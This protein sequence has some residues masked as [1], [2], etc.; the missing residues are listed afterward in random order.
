M[1]LTYGSIAKH[2][3]ALVARAVSKPFRMVGGAAAAYG[4][5]VAKLPYKKPWGR[6]VG[7]MMVGGPL[8]GA[9]KAIPAMD[10]PHQARTMNYGDFISQHSI[11]GKIGPEQLNS[12]DMDRALQASQEAGMTKL[13]SDQE[14]IINWIH[15]Q[16]EME[17]D[18]FLGAAAG[19]VARFVPRIAPAVGKVFSGAGNM[20]K[21]IP[22]ATAKTVKPGGQFSPGNLG[23][24]ALFMGGAGAMSMHEASQGAKASITKLTSNQG[25]PTF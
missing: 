8:Y 7:A 22:S 9:Y 3:P 11:N 14:S 2:G 4:K 17:K 13:N 18:A 24:G 15:Q 20:I 10:I 25:I 23:V 12:Y 19:A 6:A 16:R 1:P 21:K 5:T